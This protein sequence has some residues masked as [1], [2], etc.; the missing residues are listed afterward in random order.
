LKNCKRRSGPE[1]VTL[2][3][4]TTGGEM[5]RG[6]G[7]TAIADTDAF[8][9][10]GEVDT[11]GEWRTATPVRTKE[12]PGESQPSE[13]VKFALT[14]VATVPR[15]VPADRVEGVADTAVA[16]LFVNITLESPSR[17][18]WDSTCGRND[19]PEGWLS[20]EDRWCPVPGVC[21]W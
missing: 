6:S 18:G 2:A 9:S 16:G 12:I 20:T 17:S 7:R 5:S 8:A 1:Q 15:H 3:H 11:G 21:R 13:V 14:E 10:G 19:P 4:R